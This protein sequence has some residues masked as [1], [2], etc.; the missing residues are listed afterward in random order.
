MSV[1]LFFCSSYIDTNELKSSKMIIASHEKIITDGHPLWN[2]TIPRYANHVTQNTPMYH[3]FPKVVG[4]M[5]FCLYSDWMCSLIVASFGPELYL[6][7]QATGQL[8]ITNCS[9]VKQ[10]R[11]LA[12][13]LEMR[14]PIDLVTVVT[15]TFWNVG[16]NDRMMN[17]SQQN[18]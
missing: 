2:W 18:P 16:K 14:L 5:E 7:S 15:V 17:C 3:C 12:E 4:D 8:S 13:D 6:S 1:I 9:T 11:K 10:D